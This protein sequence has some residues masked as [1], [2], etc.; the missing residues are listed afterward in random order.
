MVIQDAEVSYLQAS[1]L[2]LKM[3]AGDGALIV[4]E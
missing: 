4:F 2:T 1:E 3:L